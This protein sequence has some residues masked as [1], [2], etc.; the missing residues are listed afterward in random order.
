MEFDKLTDDELIRNLEDARLA[1][2][3]QHSEE[4]GVIREA[5]QRVYEKHVKMLIETDPKETSRVMELQHICKLYRAEFLPELL[6]R[7]QMV[8]EFAFNEAERRGGLQRFL[9]RLATWAGRDK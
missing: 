7:F 9:D 4:W 6:E 5:M 2:T 1:H 3:V 8:G